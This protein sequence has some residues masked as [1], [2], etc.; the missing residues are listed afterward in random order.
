LYIYKSLLSAAEYVSIPVDLL[1]DE[2]LVVV[3]SAALS[4]SG[5]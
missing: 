1:I 3:A 4:I 5:K 2:M